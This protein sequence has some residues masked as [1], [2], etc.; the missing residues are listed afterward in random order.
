[1]LNNFSAAWKFLVSIRKLRQYCQLH[2]SENLEWSYYGKATNFKQYHI[3]SDSYL[4][5]HFEHDLG[6]V[7]NIS[8]KIYQSI[9][10]SNSA[11]SKNLI[12]KNVDWQNSSS[13]NIDE[14][15]GHVQFYCGSLYFV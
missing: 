15:Y 1:M 9:S 11:L 3:T 6:S 10:I 13:R 12:Y 5:C 2:L 4:P 7:K 8:D 14:F